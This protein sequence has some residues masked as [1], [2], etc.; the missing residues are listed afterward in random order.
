MNLV[1]NKIYDMHKAILEQLFHS[2]EKDY[3][4]MKGNQNFMLTYYF[5]NV[6]AMNSQYFKID[7][8]NMELLFWTMRFDNLA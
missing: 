6:K 4:T 3:F 7:T 5:M 1:L 8:S 2:E